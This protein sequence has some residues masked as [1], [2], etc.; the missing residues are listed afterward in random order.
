MSCRVVRI[1]ESKK[2]L[3]SRKACPD[4]PIPMSLP[5]NAPVWGFCLGSPVQGHPVMLLDG[6]SLLP[7]ARH[8]SYALSHSCRRTENRSTVNQFL[9]HLRT[10]NPQPS[11]PSLLL[12]LRTCSC[13][14]LHTEFSR[15]ENRFSPREAG[16]ASWRDFLPALRPGMF[17]PALPPAEG[18]L[19]SYSALSF[20]EPAT[21]NPGHR[22]ILLTILN[23]LLSAL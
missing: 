4:M 3:L 10:R 9:L 16:I 12:F 19:A 15:S 20:Y 13:S 8:D 18:S 21:P 7:D 14:S 11:T 17:F 23:L 22:H 1:T 2:R 5:Q 6:I